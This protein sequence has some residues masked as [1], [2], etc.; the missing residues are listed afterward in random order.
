MGLTLTSLYDQ[1][2]AAITEGWKHPSPTQ[3]ARLQEIN[4]QIAEC[5]AAEAAARE[6]ARRALSERIASSKARIAALES[7][8]AA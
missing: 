3:A 8:R 6:A 1:W 4:R 7:G 2:Y 5:E